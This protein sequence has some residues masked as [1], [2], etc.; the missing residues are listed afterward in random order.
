[1]NGRGYLVPV[2]K[3]ALRAPTPELVMHPCS[4]RPTSVGVLSVAKQD[5]GIR[6]RFNAR[7]R[8]GALRAASGRKSL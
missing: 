1:M 4:H 5:T 7:V 8:G 6:L 2:S 3:R